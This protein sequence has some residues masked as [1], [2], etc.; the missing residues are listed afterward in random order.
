MFFLVEGSNEP[1]GYFNVVR[2]LLTGNG[3]HSPPYAVSFG[4]VWKVEAHFVNP[5]T[6]VDAVTDYVSAWVGDKSGETDV[7]TMIA[8]DIDNNVIDTSSYTAQ[9]LGRLDDATDFGLVEIRKAGIHRLVFSVDNP[10]GAD[11]DDFT[12]NPTTTPAQSTAKPVLEYRFEEGSGTS[13]SNTGRWSST[14]G[15]NGILLNGVKSST[16]TPPGASSK[17]SLYFDGV[18]DCVAIPDDF[19]YTDDGGKTVS[20]KPLTQF[21]IEA[22]VKLATTDIPQAIIWDD[23]GHPG[24]LLAIVSGKPQFCI[25]TAANP[26]GVSAYGSKLVAGEWHHIAG[27]YDGSSLRVFI[28]G[29]D[30]TLAPVQISGPILDN[31]EMNPTASPIGIG[32]DSQPQQHNVLN[33]AGFID[34]L[35]IYDVALQ[36][37]QL[38]KGFF[39]K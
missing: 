21:T 5:N 4:N 20:S 26:N 3:A 24:V 37:G 17:Y 1:R 31:S 27:V 13:A 30:S 14:R 32:A 35:N 39:A 36:P 7:I 28:D 23:Y 12:F 18:D 22:W 9:P 34:E 8:Y 16:D 19:N 25:S 33:F 29:K 6:G 38:A 10:S 2:H 15:A 11:M